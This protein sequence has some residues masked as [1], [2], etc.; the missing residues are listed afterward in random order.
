MIQHD[1]EDKLTIKELAE[2]SIQLGVPVTKYAL[3]NAIIRPRKTERLEA[4]RIPTPRGFKYEISWG[5][6]TEWLKAY[7]AQTPTG[8]RAHIK[9]RR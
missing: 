4:D 2:A 7:K 8:A 5:I 9:N 3:R 1:P 6:F